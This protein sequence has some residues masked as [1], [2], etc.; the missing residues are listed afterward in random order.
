MCVVVSGKPM[1]HQEGEESNSP[2]AIIVSSIHSMSAVFSPSEDDDCRQGPSAWFAPVS[3][4]TPNRTTKRKTY[5]RKA[6]PQ[7]RPLGHNGRDALEVVNANLV[8]E[9]A[10]S[11]ADDTLLGVLAHLMTS[12]DRDADGQGDLGLVDVGRV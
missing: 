2:P 10:S 8:D 12:A 5:L 3:P 4:A 7:T 6:V 9:A 1:R 11:L